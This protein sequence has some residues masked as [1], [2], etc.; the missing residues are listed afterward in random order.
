MKEMK[1]LDKRRV[2]VVYLCA[3]AGFDGAELAVIVGYPVT[4]VLPTVF[5]AMT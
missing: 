4:R 1:R 5:E 2:V 3:F